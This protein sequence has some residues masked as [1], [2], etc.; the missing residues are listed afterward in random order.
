MKTTLGG[1]LDATR[2]V[3]V[4]PVVDGGGSLFGPPTATP[5]SAAAFLPGLDT[6][7]TK[8]MATARTTAND[9]TAHTLTS[10]PPLL[11]AV[12]LLLLLLLMLYPI[13]PD[14]ESRNFR[15]ISRSLRSTSSSSPWPS[16]VATSLAA[17]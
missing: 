17:P 6:D 5:T 11:L 1:R 12:E 14:S 15:T 9:R 13:P 4:T 3:V 7:T 2:F 10:T 16:S 8:I